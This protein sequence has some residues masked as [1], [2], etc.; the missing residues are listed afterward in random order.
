MRASVSIVREHRRQNS[1]AVRY[2][3]SRAASADVSQRPMF[4]G[5]VRSATSTRSASCELSGGSQLDS[6][7]TRS[8]KKRHVS[9]ATLRRNRVS[10]LF[11]CLRASERPG[12]ASQ[13][14]SN[15]EIA[16]RITKKDV[17]M[18]SRSTRSTMASGAERPA[19]TFNWRSV[20]SRCR[21]ASL[22]VLSAVVH[23]RSFRWL[24]ERL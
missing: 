23:S 6:G 3:K 4:V 5:E 22:C 10:S 12:C 19:I 20:T 16:Q 7:P 11:S 17:G 1:S 8:S 9:R 21:A 18:N 2:P 15:G 13:R 14:M 24:N